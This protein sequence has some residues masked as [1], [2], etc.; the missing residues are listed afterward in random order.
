MLLKFYFLYVAGL[1]KESTWIRGVDS[2]YSTLV[3]VCLET[4]SVLCRDEN[5]FDLS[6]TVFP[7]KI[8]S[9]IAA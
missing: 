2:I 3:G 1:N 8:V 9:I 4:S 5:V 7:Y 6:D